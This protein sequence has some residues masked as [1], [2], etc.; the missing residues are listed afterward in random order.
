ME[1]VHDTKQKGTPKFL[2]DIKKAKKDVAY[3][4]YL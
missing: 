2:P 1:Y 3:V 4:R